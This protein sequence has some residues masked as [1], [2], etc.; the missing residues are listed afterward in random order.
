MTTNPTPTPATPLPWHIRAGSSDESD[1]AFYIM[2]SKGEFIAKL[3][4]FS[5]EADEKDSAYIVHCCNTLP[6]VAKERDE[7]LDVIESLQNV[8]RSYTRDPEFYEAY[9]DATKLINRLRG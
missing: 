6:T 4:T 5:S 1:G 3:D 2:P 7:A 8:L 9:Q